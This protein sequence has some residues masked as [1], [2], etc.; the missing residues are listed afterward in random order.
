M[1]IKVLNRTPISELPAYLAY[2]QA[3][4]AGRRSPIFERGE[5]NVLAVMVVF[6]LLATLALGGLT[7]YYLNQFNKAQSTVEEQVAQAVADAKVEQTKLDEA[8]FA[9]RQK[10]PY[11]TYNAPSVFGDL[12]IA[13]PKNWNLYAEE[14]QSDKTQLNLYFHPD[15]VK[16]ASGSSD[17]GVAY[18]LR[19]NLEQTLYVE[20]V[21][22]LQDGVSKGELVAEPIRVADIDGTKYTGLVSEGK[23]GVLVMLP[24]RDKT[25][26][27]WTEAVEY[28]ADFNNVIAQIKISP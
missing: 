20:L 19:V 5:I 6:L 24:V 26:R 13:F 9:Q 22:D 3:G 25:L 18:A 15:I 1:K 16:A 8:A 21:E 4:R 23:Q 28:T 11:R 12:A 7:I 2:R 14:N 10:E 17:A 27:V